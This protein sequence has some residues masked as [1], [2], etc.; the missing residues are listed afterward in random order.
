MTVRVRRGALAL[1]LACTSCALPQLTRSPSAPPVAT[2]SQAPTSEAPAAS[3][4]PT[5][6]ETLPPPSPAA[7]LTPS[8]VPV[9]PP[10]TQAAPAPRAQNLSLVVGQ[11]ARLSYFDVTLLQFT[12]GKD[13]VSVGWKVQVCYTR[14]HPQQNSDGSTRVSTNPWS[15]RIADGETGSAPRW[16]RIDEM[17]RDNAWS[18]NYATRTIR[19]GEC[20]MGWIG[21]THG[22]P[23]LL[24]SGLRYAPADFGDVVIW[25]H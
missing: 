12:H 25:T 18:P 7:E 3:P 24:W 13:G 22:N 6:E 19:L 10:P 20:N 1:L 11:T 17:P 23:D 9:N 5:A 21:V 14:P 2:T 15:A 16:I 8:Q 4:T